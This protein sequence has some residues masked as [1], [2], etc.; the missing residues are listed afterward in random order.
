MAEPYET[1]GLAAYVIGG[2]D[3]DDILFFDG[4]ASRE[5]NYTQEVS[6]V[7]YQGDSRPRGYR[8]EHVD[9]SWSVQ[10]V[11]GPGE[12]VRSAEFLQLLNDAHSGTEPRMLF[13]PGG[14][15]HNTG[16]FP[17]ALTVQLGGAFSFAPR[18]V[19]RIHE[20]KF[21]LVEVV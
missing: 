12:L 7:K 1:P 13:W 18:K 14:E 10:A 3:V 4:F 20:Y 9:V 8:G 17:D 11:F 21:S 2:V 6:F 19:S 5:P 15:F 16:F